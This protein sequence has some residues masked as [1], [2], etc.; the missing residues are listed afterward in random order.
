[1]SSFPWKDKL[2]LEEWLNIVRP[3]NKIT[4]HSSVCS[5]HF[6]ESDFSDT[7]FHRMLKKNAVPRYFQ[8]DEPSNVSYP[9]LILYFVINCLTFIL[10]NVNYL[11]FNNLQIESNCCHDSDDN[12]SSLSPI[13]PQVLRTQNEHNYSQ[14]SHQALSNKTSSSSVPSP[15]LQLSY[16]KQSCFSN[17]T[18]HILHLV[19]TPYSSLL[20]STTNSPIRDHNSIPQ[21]NRAIDNSTIVKV[22]NDQVKFFILIL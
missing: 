3:K 21:L 17:S 8:Y 19:T 1:M 11:F 2:R 22:K 12:L 15:T 20:S 5:V 9:S 7:L 14:L 16:N 4:K 13:P 18:P 10:L 6:D